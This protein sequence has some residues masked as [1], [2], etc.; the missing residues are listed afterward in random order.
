MSADSQHQLKVWHGL[1]A[2]NVGIPD[3]RADMSAADKNNV[4]MTTDILGPQYQA[5]WRGP[6]VLRVHA[7]MPLDAIKCGFS[8][9][10]IVMF[11]LLYLYYHTVL[12]YKCCV[13]QSHVNSFPECCNRCGLH[14]LASKACDMMR[15]TSKS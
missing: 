12:A 9:V 2:D 14:T 4:K 15:Y 11:I 3:T 6:Y 7:C 1:S 8:V 5:V 13:I 10:F